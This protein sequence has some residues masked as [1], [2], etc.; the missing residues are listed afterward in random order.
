MT[1]KAY[2]MLLTLL[3]TLVGVQAQVVIDP[4]RPANKVVASS[5]SIDESGEQE[6]TAA[7]QEGTTIPRAD[8]TAIFLSEE[9]KYA[10]INNQIVYEGEKWRN[11]ILVEVKPNSVVMKAAQTTKEF[12]LLETGI[13]TTKYEDVF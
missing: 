11:A 10:I 5:E 6:D 9:N 1:L 12:K 8:L 2:I 4:T 3:M 13:I 7:I